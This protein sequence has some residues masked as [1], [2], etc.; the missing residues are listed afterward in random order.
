ML[1]DKEEK[2]IDEEEE[3]SALYDYMNSGEVDRTIDANLTC[4]YIAS[5]R[6]EIE[7]LKRE[8]ARLRGELNA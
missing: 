5:L 1:S 3:I 6:R 2:I 7:E 8:N 4:N